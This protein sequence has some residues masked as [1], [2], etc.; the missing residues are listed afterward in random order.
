MDPVN[1]EET[2]AIDYYQVI[3]N[4]IDL[5]VIQTRLNEGWYVTKAIFLADL[6]R[7]VE[8]CR[9]YNGKTHYVTEM[10]CQIERVFLSK[11]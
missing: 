3:K 5:S 9:T 1:P 7:M 11:L 6:K 10:A 2:G 8:N 4:P